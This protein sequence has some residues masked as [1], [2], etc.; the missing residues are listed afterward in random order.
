[1]K[2]P[3]LLFDHLVFAAIV[4]IGPLGWRWLFPRF[5]R[6]LAAGRKGARGRYYPLEIF[7]LWGLTALVG[8]LW[9][10]EGRPWSAL[11]LGGSSP[12]RL[13]IGWTLA[14][15]YLALIV[16]QARALLPRPEKVAKVLVAMGDSRALLPSTPGERNGFRALSFTAGI[17]EEF[18]FRGFVLWYA[19][20]W[21]GP[22]VGFLVSSAA[23]GFMHIYLGPKHVPRTTIVGILFYVMAMTAGSLVPAMLAH[24]VT[25][26]VAGELGYRAPKEEGGAWAPPSRV[27]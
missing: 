10:V 27:A 12:V 18:L 22:V 19:T 24:T 23:F 15:L 5:L 6:A 2:P 1:M 21:A 13:A 8:G 3:F 17:C 25:D 11:W 16:G 9:M 7:P 4:L 20:Q 14:V 26:L